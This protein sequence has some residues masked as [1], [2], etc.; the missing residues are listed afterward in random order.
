MNDKDLDD[1]HHISRYCKPSS[2]ENGRLL[3]S[4]FELRE[5][6]GALSVNWI[7]HY[8]KNTISEGIDCIRQVFINRGFGLSHNGR[9]A[10]L[11]VSD[12][13][14]VIAQ[15]GT[16]DPQILR[17]PTPDGLDPSHCEVHGYTHDDVLIMAKLAALVLRENLFPGRI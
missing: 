10:S 4:A 13:K 11:S 5:N 1:S 9:F 6:E 7:E 17:S 14:K 2:I 16:S 3:A 15:H 8:E 12:V